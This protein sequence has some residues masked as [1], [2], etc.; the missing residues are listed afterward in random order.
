MNLSS[1]VAILCVLFLSVGCA[2]PSAKQD[3]QGVGPRNTPAV[4]ERWGVQIVA[5]RQSAGGHM[6][7]F[8]YRVIDPEKASLLLKR[9]SEVYLIDQ[10]TGTKLEVPR[11]KLGPMRQTAVKPE[12]NRDYF[13]LFSNPGGSVKKGEKVTVVIGDFKAENLIVE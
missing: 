1:R 11:T 3:S 10:A 13:I 4:E 9:Q 8:R 5:I 7:D 12:A 2:N 6:L